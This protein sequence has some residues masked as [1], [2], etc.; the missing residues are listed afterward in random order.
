MTVVD[1]NIPGKNITVDTGDILHHW[2]FND[3]MCI[4]F[5][6][7]THVKSVNKLVLEDSAAINI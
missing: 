5:C 3:S 4:Q 6:A 1:N 2:W 7:S